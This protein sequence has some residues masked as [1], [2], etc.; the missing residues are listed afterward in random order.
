MD[1]VKSSLPSLLKGDKI[2][3][4]ALAGTD[5]TNV[6]RSVLDKNKMGKLTH[7]FFYKQDDIFQFPYQFAAGFDN[8][9]PPDEYITSR[10]M[11]IFP[12]K[13]YFLV[14]TEMVLFGV[15]GRLRTLDPGRSQENIILSRKSRHSRKL[16]GLYH[17]IEQCSPGPYL[18]LFARQLRPHWHQWGNQL[19]KT[20]RGDPL[21]CR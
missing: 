1:R 19:P 4:F 12:Y 15:R 7:R 18:E 10:I 8:K 3:Y 17:L 21:V 6:D 20:H 14:F 16:Q 2:S 13:D 11:S 9:K 5:G